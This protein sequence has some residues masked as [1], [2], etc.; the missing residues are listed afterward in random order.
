MYQNGLA[1]AGG[2]QSR[3]F[4]TLK[5]KENGLIMDIASYRRRWS[6]NLNAIKHHLLVEILFMSFLSALII[7]AGAEILN[8]LL[9]LSQSS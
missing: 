4:G 3:V 2:L 6:G 1:E 7:F 8:L 9:L 5:L